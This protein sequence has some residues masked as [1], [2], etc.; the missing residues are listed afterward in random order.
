M[1]KD[2]EGQTNRLLN[3]LP[4]A[5]RKRLG[6][7]L[8]PESMEVKQVLFE[9][10]QPID[11]VYFPE[12]AVVSILT[13]MDDRSGVEIATV[14]NEGMVGVAL[15]LGSATVPLREFS[16]VQVPGV[17]LRMDAGTFR[18]EMEGGGPLHDVMQRYA[19]AFFSQISQQ[20]ACNS[21]HSIEER[22]SRW[23]LMT[24]DRVGSDEFPLTQEFLSQMLGVRRA[25]V[26]LAVGL[27]QRAGFIRYR[28][29]W[30]TV[31]DREGLEAAS[32]ECYGVIR[33]EFD[34]LL[35]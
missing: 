15:F 6:A 21:L 5:H 26:T 3:T 20:V 16:Q 34:R 2:P 10:G 4:A 9:R 18:D 32:C 30:M 31:V 22:C 1:G 24:H 35:S 27:L 11:A 12:S 25:S 7:V 8:E 28:R 14:G 29:R 33:A 23:L 13:A 17:L 19:Q